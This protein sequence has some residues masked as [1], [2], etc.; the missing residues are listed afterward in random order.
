[1]NIYERATLAL[2]VLAMVFGVGWNASSQAAATEQLTKR[3][4]A[5]EQR[6]QEREAANAQR[7]LNRAQLDQLRMQQTAQ[8]SQEIEKLRAQIEANAK[9]QSSHARLLN[10]LAAG[11]D[12][13]AARQGTRLERPPLVDVP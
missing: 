5:A 4:A 1:V 6:D 2:T 9:A 11:V 10:Y 3:M 12:R 8:L 7:E 13:V